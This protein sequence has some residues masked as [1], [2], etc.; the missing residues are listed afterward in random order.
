MTNM[1]T[2]KKTLAAIV[3]LLISAFIL[4]GCNKSG[5]EVRKTIRLTENT[6]QATWV[7]DAREVGKINT[8]RNL[9]KLG[10]DTIYINTGWTPETKEYYLQK[11]PL[12]YASFIEEASRYKMNIQALLSNNDWALL[13]YLDGFKKEVNV[14]LNFNKKYKYKFEAVHLDIEPHLLEH[15]DDNIES[16]LAS[17]IDNLKEIRRLI[18]E[19][20][21][22]SDDDLKL[23]ID[24]PFWYCQEKY[25]VGDNNTVD[26]LLEVVD[27]ITIMDYTKKQT[28]F[29]NYAVEVLE[30]AEKHK[31][32]T[33]EI[34][35]E[36]NPDIKESIADKDLQELQTYINESV[37]EFEKYKVFKGL[38]FHDYSSYQKYVLDNMEDNW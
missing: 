29:V 7:W 9:Y 17:Y 25:N 28:D 19:H 6:P 38:S 18:N 5:T 2:K 36:F 21:E 8:V 37:P 30:I 33:V 27:G 20:N 13:E 12:M 34:A 10:M 32:M 3:S 26:L 22:E 31:D 4:T 14:I 15:W 16:Y 1:T 24:I 23:I 11:H 35:M